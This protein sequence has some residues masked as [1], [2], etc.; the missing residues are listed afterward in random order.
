MSSQPEALRN[1][2]KF[3]TAQRVNQALTAN[4]EKRALQWMAARA[5]G[6]VSSDQLTTLGL[7]A[8][9]GA[10]ACYALAH[11]DRRFLLVVVLCL[12]LNW[13][14][15]SLD[16][17]LARVRHQ[18]RP[19]YGFY[20]DHM[21]DILGA[22]AL[23]CG[24][25]LSGLLHWPVAMAMLIAFLV[26]SGESYLATYALGRFE[27]SQGIF[28]PTEIRI[29]LGLGNL[30]ALRSPWSTVFGHKWLLFDLGGTIA[31]AAMGT[32][33]LAIAVRHTAQLYRLEAPQ[34]QPRRSFVR[35]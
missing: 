29:L 25:G 10:G 35:P 30:A 9:I 33:A 15:D 27:L 6:W 1:G 19:R 8:Q 12:A 11:F 5:P 20:V 4:L 18:E 2:A 13:L 21:V 22:V 24:L 14:G 7:L 23:M 34:T 3:T 16:G 31:A 28:G 26:L 32:M 17:T